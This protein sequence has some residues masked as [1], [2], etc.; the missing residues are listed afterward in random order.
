MK[1]NILIFL[2]SIILFT[3]FEIDLNVK[4]N[5]N[6]ENNDIMNALNTVSLEINLSFG[7]KQDKF[8]SSVNLNNYAI[9]IPGTQ[10]NEE[11]IKKFNTSNSDTFKEIKRLNYISSE[12]CILGILG[13][14]AIT[15]QNREIKEMKFIIGTAYSYSFNDYSYIGLSL[16]TNQQDFEGMNILE[17]LK[18]KNIID[19]QVWFLKFNDYNKGKLV[20]G[21]YLHEMDNK[22]NKD[23]M[24][25]IDLY[26]RY[27]YLYK[28]EFDEIIYGNKNNP[29]KRVI[30]EIHNTT[31]FSINTQLIYS[32]YEFGDAIYSNFF[33]E[34]IQNNKCYQK[35][36]K[37]DSQYIYFYCKK[38]EININEMENLNFILKE[39]NINFVLEPKDL[40]YEDNGYLYY[41]IVYKPY[42]EFDSNKDTEWILGLQFLKKY[43]IAFNRDDKTAY[44]YD[45]EAKEENNEDDSKELKYIIIIVLLIIIF[46]GCIGFL[47]YY[48]IKIKPRKKKANELDEDFD[49]QNRDNKLNE[50]EEG[51]IGIG[52]N[53]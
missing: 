3:C 23:D 20:L 19:K 30:M 53:E 31:L 45:K 34:K 39:K 27:G 29:E 38:K 22:Y 52:I 49:Y 37:E 51:K 14:D 6:T 33:Y 21:K 2:T 8:E 48:I 40:F 36:L 32:T 44:Y 15:I 24:V 1:I 9:V 16:D 7:S 28:I 17:Q 18:S 35:N 11:N 4:K 46:I 25:T 13:E 47:V 43:N 42:N 26:R 12:N 50:N 10:L 5:L 41:L